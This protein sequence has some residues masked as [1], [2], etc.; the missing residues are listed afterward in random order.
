LLLFFKK[1]DLSYRPRHL[2]DAASCALYSLN[3][4]NAPPSGV[5][6]A[7]NAELEEL[8]NT[9]CWV[10]A[11][12]LREA[13]AHRT[14]AWEETLVLAFHRLSRTRRSISAE[15]FRDNP[16]WEDAHR[17]FH[18][19]LLA[20]C[21]SRQLIEF[22]AR[23]SD[24]AV[25]YRRLAMSAAFPKRDIASEHRAIMEAATEGRTDD[26]VDALVQHYRRT[27]SFI[28]K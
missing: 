10:E 21:P 20:T 26:A 28:A 18:R 6:E 8:T 11:I 5:A 3:T 2:G 13:I 23:L 16:D 4:N 24:H 25:R 12:A 9:R 22:C 27:A 15:V 14:T 19:A 1:E 7:N 17:A